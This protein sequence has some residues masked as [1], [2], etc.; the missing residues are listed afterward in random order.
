VA[1]LAAGA[2]STA[3]T[4]LTIPANTAP[5]AYR[6][7]AVADALDQVELEEANN[8]RATGSDTVITP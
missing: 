6:I 3:T 1:S 7:I 4:A 2:V 8:T 5:G